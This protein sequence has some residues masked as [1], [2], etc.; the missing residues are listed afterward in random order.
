MAR[1]IQI[2]PRRIK[3]AQD[4]ELKLCNNLMKIASEKQEEI[5]KIIQVTLQQM[6]TNTDQVLE[7]FNSR[8]I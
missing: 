2:T 7:D 1:E 4:I 6:R 5:C 8:G 3:Y